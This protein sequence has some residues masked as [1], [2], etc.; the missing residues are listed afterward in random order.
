LAWVDNP[1][2]SAAAAMTGANF[3][4]NANIRRSLGF[5]PDWSDRPCPAPEWF[6]FSQP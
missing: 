1:P 6:I 5:A 4:V 3:L 2:T